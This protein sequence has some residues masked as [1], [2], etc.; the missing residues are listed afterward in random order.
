[1]ELVE[2]PQASGNLVKQRAFEILWPRV[3]LY[4]GSDYLESSRGYLEKQ[5]TEVLSTFHDGYAMARDLERRF[6]WVEDRELVDLMDAGSHALSKAHKEHVEQWVKDC[7]IMP[8][9]M[10][11][12]TVIATPPVREDQVGTI[13]KI[14]EGEAR[15][16]V[17][18]PDQPKTSHYVVDYEDVRDVPVGITQG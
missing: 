13:V 4:L 15:Y 3:V 18:Y 10:I 8:E 17:R 1:M 2:R 5:I 11:G 12:D 7:H 9:R 6:G 14:Y 16:G